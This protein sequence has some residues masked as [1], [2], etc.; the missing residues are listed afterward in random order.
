MT[1]ADAIYGC[2]KCGKPVALVGDPLPADGLC[3]WCSDVVRPA[4]T[5][6]IGATVTTRS[7]PYEVQSTG[8]AS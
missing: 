2:T 6:G 3:Q 5:D 1:R 4:R 7:T 8:G